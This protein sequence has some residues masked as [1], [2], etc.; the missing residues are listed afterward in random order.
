MGSDGQGRVMVRAI[1]DP[2]RRVE[3]AA[4]LVNEEPRRAEGA[5]QREI[6]NVVYWY[7]I[8]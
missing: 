8:Q 6:D 7:L 5:P 1:E 4:N 2:H 3:R